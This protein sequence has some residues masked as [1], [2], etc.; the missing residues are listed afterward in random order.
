M[1]LIPKRIIETRSFHFFLNEKNATGA[2]RDV[3]I[4]VNCID[5]EGVGKN[6]VWEFSR[7]EYILED[8]YS[9][10][11]S[12]WEFLGLINDKIKELLVKLNK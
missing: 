3:E 9:L 5:D 2:D 8:K 1:E 4:M 6:F 11:L 10:D 7:C 12:D